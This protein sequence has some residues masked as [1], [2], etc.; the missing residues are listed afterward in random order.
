MFMTAF[1][2]R[3]FIVL[4]IVLIYRVIYRVI[5]RIIYRVILSDERP[6]YVWFCWLMAGFSFVYLSDGR[7]V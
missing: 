6:V 2:G 7:P 4:F 1:F 3:Y 5:Y